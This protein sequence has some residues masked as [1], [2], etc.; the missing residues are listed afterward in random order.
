MASGGGSGGGTGFDI[1]WG[2]DRDGKSVLLDSISYI[3]ID[4]LSGKSEIDAISAVPEPS[5]LALI[6]T[7]GLLTFHFHRRRS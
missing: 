2:Q 7:G 4:V 6:L 1:S 5:T 3:R